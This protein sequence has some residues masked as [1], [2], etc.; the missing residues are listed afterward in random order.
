[1]YLTRWEERALA[2]EF[3][4]ALRL[5]M[6]IVVRV[7]E[8]CGAQKLIP[9]SHAHVSGVSIFNIGEYGL[10]FLE[11][12]ARRGARVSIYT[13]ANPASIALS[14]VGATLYDKRVVDAQ[15]RVVEALIRMG[16]EPRS[17][18]CA[19]HLLREPSPREHLAWAES[20]AVILANS[21]FGARTNR[22]GGLLALAAAIAGRT[23]EAGM[24]LDENRVPTEIID[25]R[26]IALESV[27]EASLLGLAIG[28]VTG[29]VPF[30]ELSKP[31]R[32]E[33]P[34][35]RLL[36]RNLLAS[37]ATT[38]SSPLAI[39]DGVYPERV[40]LCS[41]RERISIDVS[42]LSRFL[43][44]ECRSSVALIGCPHMDCEELLELCRRISRSRYSRGIQRVLATIPQNLA[45]E[46]IDRARSILSARGIE[47]VVAPSTCAVVSRLEPLSPE[48]LTPHGKALHYI[49]KL[50]GVRA[51][52]MR[53]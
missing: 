4:E 42:E 49:P 53:V 47:L 26:S 33:H 44:G 18:T 16:V 39:V 52:P 2:G 8:F 3:G 15:R 20:S 21:V 35:S 31:L 24:H 25:A 10:E 46:C 50:A 43:E 30:V 29:G 48:I 22:E 40:E 9:V 1:M 51:C 11:D 7:G 28:S 38:S 13:T 14:S 12:L 45:S 41:A 6:E 23:Y 34:W 19:P 32:F 27:L 37:I 17:F 5:A 36:L